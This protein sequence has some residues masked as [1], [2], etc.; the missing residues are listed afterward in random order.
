MYLLHEIADQIRDGNTDGWKMYWNVDPQGHPTNPRPENNC[1]DTLLYDLRNDLR[2]RLPN[3]DAQREIQ[4]ADNKQAD[5]RIA[6]RNFQVPV[7]IKKNSHGDVWI[8]LQNQL[9]ERYARDPETGGYEIY[10]LCW[11]GKEKGQSP[12]SGIRPADAKDMKE[13]LEATLSQD[14]ARKISVSVI[15]VSRSEG[16]AAADESGI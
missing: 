6:C 4:Y 8:A 11:F 16:S 2:R 3:V 7:E 9:I 1:Q 13:K 14:Q 15:D 10:L 12:P 5:I